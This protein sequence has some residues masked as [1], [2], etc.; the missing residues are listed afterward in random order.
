MAYEQFRTK[1]GPATSASPCCPSASE[2]TDL[3]FELATTVFLEAV[4]STL[5]ASGR[6]LSPAVIGLMA[7]AGRV[8][9]AQA[10]VDLPVPG[11][12]KFAAQ[13]AITACTPPAQRALL[14]EFDGAARIARTA[15]EIPRDAGP[16]GWSLRERAIEAAALA[17]APHDIDQ[18]LAISAQAGNRSLGVRDAA[19]AAAARS[20][21]PA[22]TAKLL[23]QIEQGRAAVAV[24]V[25]VAPQGDPVYRA[26]LLQVAEEN[27]DG[28]GTASK[29]KVLGGLVA[30]WH[31]LDPQRASRHAIR[32]R[33]L[34]VELEA[35]DMLEKTP[36]GWF[37]GY[38][39]WRDNWTAVVEVAATVRAA[40][41]DLAAW[42]VDRVDRQEYSST[43]ARRSRQRHCGR[44]GGRPASAYG[45]QSAC[46]GMNRKG[47]RAGA[48]R[49]PSPNWPWPSPRPTLTGPGSWPT[50]RSGLSPPPQPRN[51]CSEIRSIP[52][53]NRSHV[54]SGPATANALCVS[55][56]A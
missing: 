27:C 3:S 4:R 15:L 1:A 23:G 21:A 50:R 12:H 14:G 37:S 34:V 36:G 20:A 19:L 24:D 48:Q 53:W 55:P 7:V 39:D 40:D 42:L 49:I 32:L 22:D 46:F 47:P 29:I 56:V 16:F 51:P 11:W 45:S 9:E 52:G 8:Q 17:L 26:L 18:A 2:P 28:E 38:S 30:G 5:R 25:A 10:R 54:C 41:P 44:H 43:T 35:G 31:P 6:A 13:Q 33:D